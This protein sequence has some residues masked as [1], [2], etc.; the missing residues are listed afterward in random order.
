MNERNY[1]VKK[2]SIC[3]IIGNIFL[4]VIKITIGIISKSMSIIADSINSFGDIFA[5]ILTFIGNKISS[6]PKDNDHNFGHGKAE[7]IFSMLISISMMIISVKLFYDSLI[8]IIS[9][10]KLI[11]SW[12]LII[13]C[14]LTI[15]TKIILYIYT[16]YIY[17]KTNNLLIKSNML[18]HRNDIFITLFTILAI[19]LTK[20]NIFFVDGLVGIGISIWIFIT[21]IKLFKESYD[22]LMDISLDNENKRKIMN[23][24]ESHDEIKRVGSFYSIPIGYKYI[25]VITIYVNGNLKTKKSHDIADKIEKEIKENV[26]IIEHIIVHIEPYN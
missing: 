14:V 26:D 3:G 11:F 9:S 24:I 22:V 10:N 12:K 25:V 4:F 18:D 6:V 21:A 5:S 1:L 7:Y 19:M 8:S 15:I 20:I 23:V 16:R 17:K 13:I 2:G